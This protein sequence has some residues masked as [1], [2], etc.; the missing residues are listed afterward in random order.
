ML[1][2]SVLPV[3]VLRAVFCV[4]CSLLSELNE[5]MGDQ[6]MLAHSITGRSNVFYVVI[7]CLCFCSSVWMLKV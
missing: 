3:I 7:V 4:F 1:V 2:S 6:M 5:M